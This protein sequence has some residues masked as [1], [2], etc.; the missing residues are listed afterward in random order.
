MNGA[1]GM[2]RLGATS[3]TDS[4]AAD[5]PGIT[6]PEALL[7]PDAAVAVIVVGDVA[8][9]RRVVTR[10]IVAG[11]ISRTICVA[12]ARAGPVIVRRGQC[13]TD[14]GTA[15]DPGRHARGDAALRLGRC[16]GRKGHSG[17]GSDCQ[18]RLLHWLD[19]SSKTRGNSLGVKFHTSLE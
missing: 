12:G 19:L 6:V 11:V 15:D 14:N 2:N 8:R 13:A 3:A 4:G 7:L 1:S 16:T 9:A 18:E 17:D 5:A 10:R